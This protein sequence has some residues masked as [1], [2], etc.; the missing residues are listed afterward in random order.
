MNGAQGGR[1]VHCALAGPAGLK[2][3]PPPCHAG[4]HG[5]GGRVWTLALPG[6]M[7]LQQPGVLGRAVGAALVR[8]QVAG[9]RSPLVGAL[10]AED[11]G[12]RCPHMEQLDLSVRALAS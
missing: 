1:G 4:A 3:A 11:L 6:G 9:L 7:R 2:P 5:I 12:A 10:G 8:L